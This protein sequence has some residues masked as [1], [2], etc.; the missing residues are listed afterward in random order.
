VPAHSILLIEDDKAIREVVRDLLVLEGY[1]V[2]PAANGKEA[3]GL[4]GR[5]ALPSLVVLDL[6]LPDMS[7]QE[8]LESLRKKPDWKRIPVII[9]TASDLSHAQIARSL[10]PATHLLAKPID[11]NTFLEKVRESCPGGQDG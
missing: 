1:E 4:S 10:N 9:L 5:I 7:G 2:H 8:I 6:M 3:L 11:V